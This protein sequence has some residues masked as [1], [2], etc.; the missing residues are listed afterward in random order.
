MANINVTKTDTFESWRLKTNELGANLGDYSSLYKNATV[1]FSGISGQPPT[2]YGGATVA[3]FS[4]SAIA[5]TYSVTAISTAGLGYNVGDV[6]NVYGSDLGGIIVTNDLAITVATTDGSTGIATVTLSGIAASNLQAESNLIR[7]EIGSA[8]LDLTTTAADIKGAVN[9]LDLRQGNAAL[10][11]TASNLSAAVNELDLR[12]GNA[13]LTTTASDLSAAVNELDASQGNAALTTTASDI[14]GAINELDSRQGNSTL[15]TTASNLSAAVNELDLRQGN[16]SLITSASDLSGAVN[17]LKT[18]TNKLGTISAAGMATTATT[19]SGAITEV[20][21]VA[22]AAAVDIGGN[23]N[24][25]Y[26]GNDPSNPGDARGTAKVIDALNSLYSASSLGTLDGEYVKRDGTNSI[27]TDKFLSVSN[28]GLTATSGDELVLNTTTT[29]NSVIT[30]TP[31]LRIDPTTGN[32]GVNKA[33]TAANRIDVSGV[34]KAT[35]FNENG[36]TLSTKYVS[37]LSTNAIGGNNTFTGDV[38]I[39]PAAGKSVIIGGSTVATD[40]ST[41]LEWVQ[42]TAADMFDGTGDLTKSYND[43]TGKISFTVDNNSHSHTSSNISD[44][45]ES[46]TDTVGAM[47][48]GN[49]ETGIS[50]LF[51]DASN[52]LNFAIT[53]GIGITTDSNGVS[54]TAGGVGATQLNVAG[55]GTSSQFLRSDGDGSFT[56]VVP[57]DTTYS[58]QD[59]QL[60]QINF[61]SADHIKLNDIATSATANGTVTGSGTTSGTNTGDNP[62]VTSV[63]T[64]G[65]I[66]GGTITSTGTITHSTAAGNKHIPTGG[67]AG[68]YLKYSSSGTAAWAD[69]DAAVSSKVNNM[70]DPTNTE[71]GISVDVDV[72]GKLSFDV[73]DP[74]IT[75]TG[76]VTGSVVMNNLGSVSIDTT[77]V[78]A[79]TLNVYDVNGSRLYP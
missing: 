60:S 72:N 40:T 39:S 45:T 78:T 54:L 18:S 58:V 1:S 59:G 5:G 48:A 74:T 28:K 69:F 27:D 66:L 73:N 6:I 51:D 70:V 49:T 65:A 47:V 41:L 21:N 25:D 29:A 8:S 14:K 53:G 22:R 30:N 71:S 52:K 3:V 50:V 68:N 34:V 9:E 13:S 20:G 33:P 77:V 76:D 43:T 16:A 37:K 55:N 10:T 19:V 2:G 75:L 35:S 7:D 36:T 12:Q 56:W 79:A 63:A 26:D 61:T 23:M 15:T 46:V 24:D 44:W 4:I 32:I 57:T 17:E 62:G 64:S 11:T 31:R 67:A 42:D 38:T